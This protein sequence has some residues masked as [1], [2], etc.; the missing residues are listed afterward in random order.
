VNAV[1]NGAVSGSE[2]AGV[3]VDN[4]NDAPA[5]DRLASGNPDLKYY[6]STDPYNQQG[7][8]WVKGA[9]EL[10]AQLAI[11]V[12]KL[13]KVP[14]PFID[15]T[16]ERISRLFEMLERQRLPA[17]VDGLLRHYG[18]GDVANRLE[19]IALAGISGP[20][21]TPLSDRQS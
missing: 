17:I 20:D 7:V 16:L 18:Y 13:N 11:A 5:L 6:P 3:P 12:A 8:V 2:T 14:K 19:A 1:A 9:L 21:P 4:G 15:E 10:E